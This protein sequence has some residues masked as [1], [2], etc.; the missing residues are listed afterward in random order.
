MNIIL[1]LKKYNI[2]IKI[3]NLE[4]LKKFLKFFKL[5]KT[6]V[7]YG[8][9]LQLTTKWITDWTIV[10][11]QSYEHIQRYTSVITNKFI[12][13]LVIALVIREYRFANMVERTVF[14]MN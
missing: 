8:V 5:L 7:L 4:F 14:T 3:K 2:K 1:R 10:V 11:G 9:C 13:L 12:G 6:V